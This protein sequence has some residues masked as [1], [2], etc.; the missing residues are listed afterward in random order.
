MSVSTE[1]WL[2][3]LGLGL[4]VWLVPLLVQNGLFFIQLYNERI[5]Y[6]LIE[7]IGLSV[8]LACL[9]VYLPGVRSQIIAE[10]WILGWTWMLMCLGLNVA[11]FVLTGIGNTTWSA[12]LLNEGWLYLYIPVC[13][14]ACGYLSNAVDVRSTP[15]G[16]SSSILPIR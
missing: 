13:A 3:I 15:M 6:A 4:I 14:I 7:L 16:V 11:F 10:G 2:K 9:A 12:Y 5:F 1:R 8:A